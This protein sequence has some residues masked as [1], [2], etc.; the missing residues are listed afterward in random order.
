MSLE[1]DPYDLSFFL[2]I[3][4]DLSKCAICAKPSIGIDIDSLPKCRMCYSRG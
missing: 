1:D 2:A 3:Y 4:Q